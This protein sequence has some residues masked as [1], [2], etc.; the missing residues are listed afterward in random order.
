MIFI[1]TVFENIYI[2]KPIRILRSDST[3]GPGRV[4]EH[5]KLSLLKEMREREN[6]L[7]F[8]GDG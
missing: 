3:V 1:Y 6:E 5:D 2:V 4:R 7:G 8:L